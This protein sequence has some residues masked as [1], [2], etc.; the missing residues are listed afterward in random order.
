MDDPD[1]RAAT[2]AERALLNALEAGCSA[3]V[4]AFADVAEGEEGPEL[5]LRAVVTSSDGS[6]NVRLSA[7]GTTVE[8]EQLGRRL[9]AELLDEGAAGLIGEP[10]LDRDE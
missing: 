9:A 7:T 8:A 5:Y 1:S 4:G 6:V 10:S 2:T 3:P